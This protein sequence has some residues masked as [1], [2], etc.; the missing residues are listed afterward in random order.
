MKKKKKEWSGLPS[1]EDLKTIK[2]AI[3]S[4]LPSVATIETEKAQI[5]DIYEECHAKTAIPRRLFN[6]LLKSE[7]DGTAEE[8]IKKADD[9]KDAWEVYK[10]A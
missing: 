6:F 4:A 10:T 1:G 5:K 7:H 3:Q 8:T 2:T 9:L